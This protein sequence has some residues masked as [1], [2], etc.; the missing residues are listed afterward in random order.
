MISREQVFL[1]FAVVSFCLLV[2]L[3]G[4]DSDDD[5]PS[6]YPPNEPSEPAPADAST[7]QSIDVDL[8]WTCSDSDG[9]ALTFDVY[10]GTSTDPTVVSSGQTEAAPGSRVRITTLDFVAPG[11][12]R[13]YSPNRNMR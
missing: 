3:V 7:D 12:L 8:S 13:I 9:D 11:R 1:L 6:N 2:G 5:S 4:C 10:L